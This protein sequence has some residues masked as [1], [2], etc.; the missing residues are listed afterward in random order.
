ML[1]LRRLSVVEKYIKEG[2][3]TLEAQKDFD[4]LKEHL[5]DVL[6]D[7]YMK[8]RDRIANPEWKDFGKLKKK[9]PKEVKN[10]VDS[11]QS[12]SD[13]RKQDKF[14]GSEKLYED[15]DWLVLK[16]TSYPAAQKYGSGTKWCITGRYAGHEDRGETYFNNYIKDN[17]LDGGYY[18]Y[19]NKKNSTK[20]YCVLQKKDKTI[21]SIWNANDNME[22]VSM[23]SLNVQ[24]P[25]IP[26]VNLKKEYTLDGLCVLCSRT[27]TDLQHLNNYIKRLQEKEGKDIVNKYDSLN[28]TP[29]VCACRGNNLDMV[30]L[31]VKAGADVNNKDGDGRS[32][33]D[34]SIFN[35][36]SIGISKDLIKFLLRC[37]AK[38]DN[39]NLLDRLIQVYDIGNGGFNFN[40]ILKLLIAG[41]A[42]VNVQNW[43]GR[44]PIHTAIKYGNLDLIKSLIKN[45]ADV[46]IKDNFGVTP[47]LQ[48]INEEELKNQKD[49]LKFL[50]KN[51]ADVNISYS[52]GMTP[53]IACCKYT[54]NYK[55]SLP[56][57]K[58]LV[59][60]GA[61]IN[62]QDSHGNTALHYAIKYSDTPQ[63]VKYLIEHGADMDIEND[64]G[65]TPIDQP[66]IPTKIKNY[67][68][69]L[70][71]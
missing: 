67:L 21:S 65:W 60:N 26:E 6:F 16:I 1:K 27:D 45:G 43:Y 24:L 2:K 66:M 17:N 29:L 57:I 14:S 35:G 46:N 49:I 53:L 48:T 40:D 59:E 7:D 23:A 33:I 36:S 8:I 15:D 11:F 3:L 38:V 64:S 28:K 10:F 52:S 9:D 5:G 39:K 31:L 19:I 50:I 22:G 63:S 41:G 37:G 55:N 32:P 62:A 20:K 25:E 70:S 51:G 44:C 56:L 71:V 18:F 12:K 68:S 13:K 58:I 54:N 47:I 61:N 42:D 34:V 4:D 30:K 69:T